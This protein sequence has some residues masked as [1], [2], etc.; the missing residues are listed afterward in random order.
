MVEIKGIEKFTGQQS[1]VFPQNESYDKVVARFRAD[2]LRDREEYGKAVA[3]NV[4]SR[5]IARAET[6][7]VLNA[8]KLR[9][10]AKEYGVFL[11]DEQ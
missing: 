6:G 11:E 8:E 5:L 7:E 1:C 3:R 2:F 4:F 10:M 9:N